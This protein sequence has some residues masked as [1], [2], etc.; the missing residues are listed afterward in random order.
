[1]Y[2]VQ[3]IDASIGRLTVSNASRNRRFL[4][5]FNANVQMNPCHTVN[6]TPSNFETL[7]IGLLRTSRTKG[8]NCWG[9]TFRN[10]FP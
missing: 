6:R 5:C 4:A 7:I 8:R 9:T 1:M 10:V 2:A 3:T